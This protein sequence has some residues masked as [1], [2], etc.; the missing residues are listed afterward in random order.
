[1]RGKR[2]G[3]RLGRGP[4][5]APIRR[6]ALGLVERGWIETRPLGEARGRQLG[7]RGEP[8]EGSPNLVVSERC[9]CHPGLQINPGLRLLSVR[10][11]YSLNRVLSSPTLKNA[12]MADRV[13]ALFSRRSAL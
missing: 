7:P 6:D 9:A 2:F 12:V 1:R 10:M 5:R 3:D 13:R 4:A 8:V 11:N